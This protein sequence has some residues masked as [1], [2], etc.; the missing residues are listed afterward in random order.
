MKFTIKKFIAIFAIILFIVNAI[1]IKSFANIE[2]RDLY[3]KGT[4][5]RLLKKGDMVVK[6]SIVVYKKDGKEYPAYCLDKTKQGVDEEISYSVDLDGVIKN[7]TEF[8]LT[9]KINIDET[10]KDI[11]LNFPIKDLKNIL[12][13]NQDFIADDT[14]KIF[15]DKIIQKGGVYDL[16]EFA[17]VKGVDFER[18]QNK[19]LE[20]TNTVALKDFFETYKDKADLNRVYNRVYIISKGACS[21]ELKLTRENSLKTL[22]VYVKEARRK[23]QEEYENSLDTNNFRRGRQ[24]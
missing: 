3:S 20:S 1:N 6:T 12:I 9:H 8:Y 17:G 15:E 13:K 5:G 18:I 19:I 24:Y 14:L 11:L 10:N 23:E 4:C 16:I 21:A 7:L 2:K 22:Q